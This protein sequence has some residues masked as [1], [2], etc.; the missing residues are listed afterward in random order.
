MSN[1]R[2]TV[3]NVN[4]Y[5]LHLFLLLHRNLTVTPTVIVSL[6]AT[7]SLLGFELVARLK[8]LTCK[9]DVEVA[10]KSKETK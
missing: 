9:K 1:K 7:K 4:L 6:L 2:H 3:L 8:H 5:C 10:L